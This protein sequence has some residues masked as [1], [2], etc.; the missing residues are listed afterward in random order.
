MLEIPETITLASQLRQ[1]AAGYTV[2]SVLTP[3]KPHKF[4]FFHPEA[5]LFEQ[6]LKGATIDGAESYGIFAEISFDNGMKLCVNDGVNLRF[7]DDADVPASYQL[8]ICLNDGKNLL[9]SVAMYGGISLHDGNY[10]NKYYWA[11]KD[12][13]SPFL[14]GFPEEFD[15]RIAESK[16]ALSAKAFLATEQRFPGIGNGV[17]QDIL[18]AAGIHPKRKICT[19]NKTEK[20]MLREAIVSVLEEMI[21]LGGRDTEK[22]LFDRPGRYM[23]VMSKN[24]VGKPCPGCGTVIVK[25]SYMGG[26]V[27]YCPGCQK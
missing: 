24:T 22:D 27:Y 23:T 9:F 14:D 4:C 1:T 10:D 25:E 17:L 16:P 18:F 15:K 2:E 8:R 5:A 3:T 7:F 13:V 26:S 11:N 12:A 20:E 19:L 21:R 6:G